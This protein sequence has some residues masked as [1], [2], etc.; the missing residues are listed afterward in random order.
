MNRRE[1]LKKAGFT[2]ASAPFLS[3]L[4]GCSALNNA[5]P[6]NQKPNIIYILSDDLGYGDIGCF[7]QKTIKTPNLDKMASEGIR[8]TQH[9]AGDT[10]CAPSR[11]VLMTGLH[12][13][14]CFIRGNEKWNLRPAPDDL[15]VAEL[16]KQAGYT[17]ALIGK[18]G[19]GHEGSTGVPT[20][21][22]FDYFFGY[23]DQS[24]AHNYYPIFLLRNEQRVPLDNVVPNPGRYDT[25]VATVRKQYSHDLFTQ[26]AL[27][28]V[29]ASKQ[30]PFFLY[31]AYTIPHANGEAKEKGMEV[32]S[33]EPYENETWPE[34]AKGRAAMIT[35]MD[36]DIGSL[37]ALLKDLGIDNST[38]VFFSS[39]NGP[40]DEGGGKAEF[41]HSSGPYRGIKRDLYEGGI[42]VPFIARWPGRI[43]PSAQSDH[44]SAF[45]DFLPTCAELVGLQPPQNTDGISYLPTL[46]GKPQ[47]QK[48]HDYLYWEFY[49][50]GGKQAVRK[51]DYKLIRL[52]ENKKQELYNLKSDPA[53]QNNIF[54]NHP[55]IIKQLESLLKSAHTPDPHY[56]N[57]FE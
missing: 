1:F 25:G 30:G 2:A 53:E 44:M 20:K 31:L 41:F 34:P 10:V 17:N 11:C 52:H 23:L 42:R 18:W 43:E 15:T 16:L 13:G 49:E 50:E 5:S 7:G 33:L 24:H 48:H 54:R 46:L 29:K 37:F 57:G 35:R 45:Q 6:A 21:K 27:A 36:R 4:T 19:L 39:D 56:P 3:A 38:L 8:F 51:G 28:W 26:E 55:D 47:S 14:H 40:A 22:G 9:Y 32:P 12:T